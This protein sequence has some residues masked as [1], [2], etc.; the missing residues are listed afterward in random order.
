MAF[1]ENYSSVLAIFI[2]GNN[3]QVHPGST[4]VYTGLAVNVSNSLRI[5][6]Y[7]TRQAFYICLF[8]AGR[9]WQS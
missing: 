3:L 2:T 7:S 9:K 5:K 4:S 6:N 8:S 1:R